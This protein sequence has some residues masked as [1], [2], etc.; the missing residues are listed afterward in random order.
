MT[1]AKAGNRLSRVRLAEIA[2]A[3]YSQTGSEV[4]WLSGVAKIV[5]P[6]IDQGEGVAA[7]TFRLDTLTPIDSCVANAEITGVLQHTTEEASVDESWRFLLGRRASSASERLGMKQGFGSVFRTFREHRLEDFSA[8]TVYDASGVG[9]ALAAPSRNVF[10]TPRSL[11]NRLESIGAHLLTGF[12]LRRGLPSVDAVFA[13]DG[14]LLDAV[15]AARSRENAERLRM[16][17]KAFDWA[18]SKRA[19]NS[20]DALQ[21]WQA[22]VTGR[23][24]IVQSF[25]SDGRRYLLAKR[26]APKAIRRASLSQLE[27]QA[28]ILRA[29]GLSYKIVAYEL[30]ISSTAACQLVQTGKR[31]LGIRSEAEIVDMIR[32]ATK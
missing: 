4:D 6:I 13:P 14:K 10:T 12:R 11:A 20:D 3:C 17:V 21:A 29:Q 18:C 30:G 16:A 28:L 19:S 27:S 24:S 2:D 22:L 5:G 8:L 31:K 32:H 23:W 1:T 15:G 25:E 7:W 9:V 26:N